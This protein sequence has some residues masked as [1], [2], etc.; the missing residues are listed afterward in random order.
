MLA[1]T[2]SLI[3]TGQLDEISY[4]IVLGNQSWRIMKGSM[5]IAKGVKCGLLY[6]MHVSSI[7]ENIVAITKLP[8]T[9]LWHCR[10]GHISRSG[11]ESLTH[12]SYLLVFPYSDFPFCE[13]CAYGKHAKSSHKS[14]EKKQL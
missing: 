2:K 13:F 6:P 5:V 10:L 11:M 7:N 9:S 3:S 1:L 4:H 12:F 14:L 8:S